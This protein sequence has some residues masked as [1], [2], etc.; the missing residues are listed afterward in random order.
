MKENLENS[1]FETKKSDQIIQLVYHANNGMKAEDIGNAILGMQLCFSAIAKVQNHDKYE[2]LVFP[3]EKGSL[4]TIFKV[5][6]PIG[7]SVSTVVGIFSDSINIIQSFGSNRVSNPDPEVLREVTNSK[8]LETCKS[9][10]FIEGGQKI[11]TPLNESVSS[12]E[13]K[14]DEK[15]FIISCEKKDKFFEGTES[16]IFPELKNGEKVKLAGEIV[17]L[18]KDYNDLGFRYKG[19]KL[20]CFPADLDSKIVQ[21]H[22]FMEE[23]QVLMEG[24]VLRLNESELPQIQILSIQRI[25]K[26]E[27][28]TLNFSNFK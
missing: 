2:L 15:G 10:A 26:A 1:L 6:V 24:V 12:L 25:T 22:D 3:I 19:R 28:P 7:I 5:I 4:K 8:I 13:I 27:Q 23:E 11:V 14:Y 16:E 17:R 18:N 9:R 20:K 21:F